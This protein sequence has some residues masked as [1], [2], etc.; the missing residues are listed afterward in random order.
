MTKLRSLEEY[1]ADRRA[2]YEPRGQLLNGIA[3][4]K[5]GAELADTNPN[6]IM[7]SNPP[8]TGVNCSD[9]ACGYRGYR[10]A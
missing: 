6:M 10:V 1:N 4:P 5:C 7:T 8:Q 2:T 3:C 9:Q